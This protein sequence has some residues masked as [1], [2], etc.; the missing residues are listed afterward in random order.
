MTQRTAFQGWRLYQLEASKL[1]FP[2]P[3]LSE[4]P[5]ESVWPFPSFLRLPAVLG[6][7]WSDS[8]DKRRDMRVTQKL[9][10]EDSQNHETL[11]PRVSPWSSWGTDHVH[12]PTAR[13]HVHGQVHVQ[14]CAAR[15]GTMFF[16]KHSG[17]L[18]GHINRV[19]RRSWKNMSTV[20]FYLAN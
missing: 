8:A 4:V 16:P 6:Y 15:N 2:K 17:V 19:A 20:I 1:T 3:P 11:L 9:G 14:A 7:Y 18:P 5:E 10:E 13:S 12:N